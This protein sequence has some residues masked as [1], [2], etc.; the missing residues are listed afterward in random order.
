[1]YHK[2]MV[3]GDVWNIYRDPQCM[4]VRFHLQLT[5]PMEACL[6]CSMIHMETWIQMVYHQDKVTIYEEKHMLR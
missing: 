1:M 2:K 6:Q 5:V 3:A 4:A